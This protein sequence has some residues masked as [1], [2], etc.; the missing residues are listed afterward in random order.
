[1]KKI[2]CIPAFALLAVPVSLAVP[3][4][5]QAQT[6]QGGYVGLEGA[7]ST[8]DAD[9]AGAPGYGSI[10]IDG[11]DGG[12][13]GGYN[14]QS[15]NTVVGIEAD[16]SLGGASGTG[17]MSS[18]DWCGALAP[19]LPNIDAAWKY[20]ITSSYSLRARAGYEVVVNTM[21]FAT[22]GVAVANA[23]WKNPLGVVGVTF[24]PALGPALDFSETHVGWVLGAGFEYQ[25]GANIRLKGEGLYYD[26]GDQTYAVGGFPHPIDLSVAAFRVGLAYTF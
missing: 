6:F 9:Y 4:A 2:L 19:C 13:Y 11:F 20:D 17:S 24:N 14:H 21:I 25:I 12:I 5:A 7:Y 23:D 22:G 18:T 26:Y 1:M 3:G 16:A 10:S 15:G 8:G